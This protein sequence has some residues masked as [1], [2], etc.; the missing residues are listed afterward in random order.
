MP[1]LDRII[2]FL[3]TAEGRCK[4]GKTIQYSSRIIQWHQK[5]VNQQIHESFR[6]LWCKFSFSGDLTF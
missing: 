1:D 2:A 6:A 4:L 3:N 5:G